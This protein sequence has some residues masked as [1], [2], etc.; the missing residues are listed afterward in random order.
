[1]SVEPNGILT[2]LGS[3]ITLPCTVTHDHPLLR[4]YWTRNDEVIYENY[5][6]QTL[7]DYSLFIDSVVWSDR[8]L[9]RCIA[10]TALDSDSDSVQVVIQ[11]KFFFN[12][13]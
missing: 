12:S 5:I 4:V 9:Y 11:S 2:I 6:N 1:M 8:G 10:E 7:Q 13:L 3:E